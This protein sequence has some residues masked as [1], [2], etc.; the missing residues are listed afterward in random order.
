MRRGWVFYAA[1][2]ARDRPTPL[3]VAAS[4]TAVEGMVVSA[5]AVGEAVSVSSARLALGVSAA[6]F[7]AAYAA[8]LLACAWGLY[9]RRQWARAPIVFAQLI[10]LGLAWNLRGVLLL[11]L[12]MAVSAAVVIA[13]T[14]H[15]D[16][17]A[18]TDEG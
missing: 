4:L 15:P 1:G 16:S 11:A 8:G 5:L 14:L 3:V 7:F 17:L 18:A 9:R 10:Q 13:G 2:M 6:A 12:A